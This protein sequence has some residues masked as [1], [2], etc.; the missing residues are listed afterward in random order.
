V[1]V[2]IR[3]LLPDDDRDAFRSGNAD[4]DRFLSRYAGQN[5]FR[6]H[7]GT[8]YVAVDAAGAILGYATVAASELTASR[9]PD[10]QRRRL[11]AYPLPVLRVARLAVD[12]RAQRQGIGA[13][14]LRAVFLLARKMATEIGCVGVVVDA[15]PEAVGFYRKLGFIILAVQ[16]GELGD[17]P[18][19]LPMFLDL[20]TIAA[21]K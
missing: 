18:Q 14:L 20:G 19:P 12:L 21:A 16:S 17:R 15:K 5:Q 2:T 4:L 1:A 11:P 10:A 9:L 7:I 6:H 3:R 8:T 13:T